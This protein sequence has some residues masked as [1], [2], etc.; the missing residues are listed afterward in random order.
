MSCS[1][2]PKTITEKEIECPFEKYIPTPKAVMCM[3]SYDINWVTEY[4][5]KVEV[6][7][8]AKK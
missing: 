6:C 7:K 8:D 4:N 2:N 1:S 3:E 5:A